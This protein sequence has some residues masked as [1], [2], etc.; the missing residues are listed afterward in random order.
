MAVIG[1][2]CWCCWID[3]NPLAFGIDVAGFK[4][5]GLLADR[6]RHRSLIHQGDLQASRQQMSTHLD[7]L[8]QAGCRATSV[9]DSEG[10]ISSSG[11]GKL[12]LC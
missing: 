3:P 5:A 1:C 6:L 7:R 9:P 11:C 2:G 8:N 10:L 12:K 4:T